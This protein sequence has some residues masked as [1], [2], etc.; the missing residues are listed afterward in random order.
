MRAFSVEALYEA[1]EVCKEHICEM[2]SIKCSSTPSI[3]SDCW[4]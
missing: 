3:R 1:I 4:A 2:L